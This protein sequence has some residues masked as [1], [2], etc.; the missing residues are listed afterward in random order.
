MVSMDISGIRHETKSIHVA[1]DGLK[2]RLQPLVR[3]GIRKISDEDLYEGKGWRRKRRQERR[4]SYLE[5]GSFF[6]L[7]SRRHA[8]LSDGGGGGIRHFY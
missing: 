7:R 4:A 5:R 3:S 6:G 2:K 1:L 8:L